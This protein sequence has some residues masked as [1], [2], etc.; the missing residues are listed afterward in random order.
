MP[1]FTS[2]CE[3][4]RRARWRRNVRKGSVGPLEGEKGRAGCIILAEHSAHAPLRRQ[5]TDGRVAIGRSTVWASARRDIPIT[6]AHETSAAIRPRLLAIA[7]ELF[8]HAGVEMRQALRR[9]SLKK[10]S[11]R[12]ANTDTEEAGNMRCREHPQG[13]AAASRLLSVLCVSSLG[14]LLLRA[15]VWDKSD[16]ADRCRLRVIFLPPSDEL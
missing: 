13:K 12:R 2:T 10:T 1:P 7:T 5:S 15:H 3:A 11:R 4:Q 6:P 16:C 14:S 9:G 8:G